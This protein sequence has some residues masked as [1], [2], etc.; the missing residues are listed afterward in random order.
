MQ[1]PDLDETT[2]GER[3]TCPSGKRG[4][5]RCACS[6]H[7]TN[8]C[9]RWGDPLLDGSVR[10][11]R[12]GDARDDCRSEFFTDSEAEM[13]CVRK[14][15]YLGPFDLCSEAGL[16]DLRPGLEQVLERD[17]PGSRHAR[18]NASIAPYTNSPRVDRLSSA[19]QRASTG[20]TC[21]CG[22]H[23][24]L[25]KGTRREIWHQDHNYWPL[26][27][28]IVSSAWIATDEATV[29]NSCVQIIPGRIARRCRTSK[30]PTIWSLLK[31]AIPIISI[32]VS[33]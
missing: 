21:C 22:V 9:V 20:R 28:P 7:R 17:A 5:R 2:R 29:E 24:L 12:R 14:D 18:A 33:W 15:G 8:G 19:P 13:R 31:W 26:E 23:K 25:C 4:T 32:P 6:R 11:S 27:P 3:T 30:R 10:Y 16:A 1:L